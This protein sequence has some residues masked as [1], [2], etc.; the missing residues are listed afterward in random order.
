MDLEESWKEKE[1]TQSGAPVSV[2]LDKERAADD[3]WQMHDAEG[4]AGNVYY[5][6]MPFLVII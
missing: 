6:R 1:R 4:T 2:L 3:A 5:L